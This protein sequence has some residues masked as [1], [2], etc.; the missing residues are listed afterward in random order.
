MLAPL[1]QLALSISFNYL[2]WHFLQAICSVNICNF[3]T[4][5]RVH[6][7]KLGQLFLAEFIF[8]LIMSTHSFGLHPAISAQR[9]TLCTEWSTTWFFLS[10]ATWLYNYANN[11]FS[12]IFLWG[13]TYYFKFCLV[14]FFNLHISIYI[15]IFNYLAHYLFFVYVFSSFKLT[16][17]F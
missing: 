3:H 12:A 6:S 11:F 7:G 14:Q 4:C 16:V 15:H 13:L 17:Y 1:Y 8:S 10:A 5:Y 9:N 2:C